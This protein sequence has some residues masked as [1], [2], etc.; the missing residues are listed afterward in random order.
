[1]NLMLI[2]LP[3]ASALQLPTNPLHFSTP[4]PSPHNRSGKSPEDREDDFDEDERSQIMFATPTRISLAIPK[5]LSSTLNRGLLTPNT[6]KS[7][8]PS[9]LESFFEALVNLPIPPKNGES[10]SSTMSRPRLI[11]IRDFPTLA[12]TSSIWYPP[13]LA[14][15]RQRRRRI[16]SRTSNISSSSVA[17][18]FGMTPP[19]THPSG[20]SSGSSSNLINLLTN[21]AASSSQLPLGG[22]NEHT[23]DWGESEAAEI[24]REKR[25]RSRLRKWEKNAASLH[26]EFP[27]L[28][29]AA[30]AEI[31]SKSNI[32]VV[33]GPDSPMPMPPMFGV[34]DSE[35]P[36]DPNSQFFRSTI[37]VPRSRS[38]GKE[39]ES[40]VARRREIN[41]LTMRMGVG[42]IGG[43]I[44]TDPASDHFLPSESNPDATI[45]EEAPTK[46]PSSNSIWEDWGN[47]VELWS[48]VRKISDRAMGSIMASRIVSP[49]REKPA[50]TSTVVPWSA[51]LKAWKSSHTMA[52][53]RKSWLKETMG[54]H[55]VGDDVSGEKEKLVNAGSGADK[56]VET[57]RNDPELDPHEA[58][59]LP[60]IV[61]SCQ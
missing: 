13:L 9:K 24:A 1:M 19:V 44:E 16:L 41:E 8:S 18:V 59:L 25:L 57:I 35:P 27:S 4:S 42:A 46:P 31:S 54:A 40:R 37:L 30:E 6:R 11:Y 58:R 7:P 55:P 12:P 51:I 3:A 23:Y 39:R 32:I 33:G 48:D 47:K 21:R 53:A 26:E 50:L 17:I 61:D 14:A 60:C 43:V 28:P 15:V 56:V 45:S 49:E 10:L 22:K 5:I 34:D 52:E 29:S 38:T 36:P 2:D 20:N